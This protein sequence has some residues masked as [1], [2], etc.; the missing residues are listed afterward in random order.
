MVI[1]GEMLLVF[2]H[3]V[4][5]QVI[6]LRIRNVSLTQMGSLF[7]WLKFVSEKVH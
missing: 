7:G 4:E 5:I 1:Q 3:L 6:L 2:Q